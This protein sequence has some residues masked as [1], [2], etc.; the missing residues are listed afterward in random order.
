[1]N[2]LNGYQVTIIIAVLFIAVTAYT[3]IREN[4]KAKRRLDARI[5]NSWGT[6]PTREYTYEEFASISNYIWDQKTTDFVI[7]DITWNDLEMDRIYQLINQT[8][9]SC[10]EVVLY[11]M[12]RKPVFNQNELNERERLMKYFHDNPEKRIELQRVLAQIGKPVGMSIWDY[13]Q[14]L[15]DVVDTKK[16]KK[17]IISCVAGIISVCSLLLNPVIGVMLLV[18]VLAYNFWDYFREKGSIEIYLKSFQC[19]LRLLKSCDALCKLDLPQIQEYQDTIAQKKKSLQKF[20]RGSFVVI[21]TG[22][23]ST[24]IADA[25]LDFFKMFLHVDLIKLYS[26][27][28]EVQSKKKEIQEL[29][30]CV[31]WLDSMI[32]VSSF[33]CCLPHYAIPVFKEDAQPAIHVEELY[34]P[35]IENPVSNSLDTRRSVLLTGSNASGKSTFLK[36]IALN[37]LLAQTTNTC[38]AK[39]YEAPFFKIMTSMALRDD[40]SGGESYYMV[41]IR[42]LKRIFD[43]AQKEVPI[44]CI[45]DEVLR[46][47]NTIERISASSSALRTLS[48][49]NVLV[50]A[51]T[52]DIELTYLLEQAYDNY[53]F[54]EIMSETDIQFPYKLYSGRS[55]TRNAI[56]LLKM[57][58]FPDNVTQTAAKQAE[59]FEKTGKWEVLC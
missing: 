35:F 54:K 28:G 2:E 49:K 55:N 52:H 19:V 17:H 22:M 20:R 25:I 10:G 16:Q 47:T 38:V 4:A 18:T 58:G 59:D 32:A 11:S 46:G 26:M 27:I 13:V 56:Q 39:A 30:E 33:R 5:R 37:S 15:D 12:L 57:I 45:I 41:E 7:D 14:A 36:N 8:M 51:A 48:E 9:C 3:M 1:M 43:E 29:V 21:T 6:V 50:F 24:G 34:H 31:G 44:L 23:V 42:S 53:H 40:L